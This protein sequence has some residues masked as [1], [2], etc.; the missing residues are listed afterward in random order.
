MGV[1]GNG[2]AFSRC[3]FAV[4]KRLGK[5]VERNRMRR[6]LREVVRLRWNSVGPG[7]DVVFAAR[8]PLR[9][10]DFADICEAVDTLLRRA[11]LRQ[12]TQSDA[13]ATHV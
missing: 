8:E 10:A 4:G 6:R 11:R 1:L 2:L 7:W 5:A 12:E 13:P 9:D 3:G